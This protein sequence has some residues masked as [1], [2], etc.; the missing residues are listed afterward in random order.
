M[1]L[2]FLVERQEENKIVS[3][4]TTRL[5]DKIKTLRKV[6]GLSEEGCLWRRC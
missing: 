1:E 6:E 2:A 4:I 3:V 5:C